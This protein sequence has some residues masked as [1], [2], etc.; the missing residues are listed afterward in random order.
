MST[1]RSFIAYHRDVWIACGAMLLAVFLL[2][3]V[4][5]VA[6]DDRFR[7]E[8][9][10]QA[11]IVGQNTSAAL[12]FNAPSDAFEVLAALQVAPQVVRADLVR[13]DGSAFASYRHPRPDDGW[14]Q[15]WAG[16]ETVQHPIT[17]G[18]QT[19]GRLIVQA[20]R[21]GILRDLAKFWAGGVAVMAIALVLSGFVSRGLRA[22]VRAAQERNRYLALH[23]ALTGLPNRAAFQDAL[24]GAIERSTRQGG[25]QALMFVDVDNFK[26]IN[27]A[28]GHG[29]GDR[30]LR[31]V[32][33]RLQRI[34]RPGDMVAR[35]GGDEFAVLIESPS[36][37]VAAATRV[38]NDL[39]EQVPQAIDFEGETLRVSVSV[40][41]ALLPRDARTA[42]DAMQCADAAMYQA[43]REGKDAYR[44]F[45]AELGEEIRRRSVMEA[46]LRVAISA[47]QLQLHYQPV[48][49]GAGRIAGM[50][51]LAR[52]QHPV[53][54]LVPPNEFIPLAETTGLIV[55]LGLEALR[56][57][58]RDIDAW[59]AQGRAVPRVALNLASTQFRRDAHRRRF[60]QALRGHALTPREV[61]FELTE[62]AV[63]EDV[64]SPDSVL[65]ALRRDGY[66]LAIDDF[67][68]G[69]SSLSFLRQLKCPKLKIDRMF[70]RD[71]AHSEEA[72][73][74]I[75]AI[76]EVAHALGMEVVA[77][78]VE[79]EIERAKLLSLGCDLLQGFLLSRP[80]P[81]GAV[82][83]LLP[84]AQPASATGVTTPA[85]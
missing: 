77:E 2:T 33:E 26:Q 43:K 27:D 74:L 41:I 24:A 55:D 66:Q 76:I 79:T 16:L 18:G 51:A 4:Q 81:P 78:G 52:W 17:A 63:F 21:S 47:G 39:V 37:P 25:Q 45:S 29:G 44:F 12:I 56:L 62:T 85:A 83:P 10:T 82:Q 30:V 23:D 28:T 7:L 73:L 36:H 58:R 65:R 6:L 80:L 69:Y 34:V 50:E 32:G 42:D 15:R 11:R 84:A 64:G 38:A 54:G 61:E 57:L 9:R 60:L 71:I 68:T 19:V 20:D 49:D 48:Y 5:Y 35:I 1:A 31:E 72:V 70:V 40:G 13:P 3:A 75:R 8:M 14:L 46:E 22:T 67:G 53:R 59:R